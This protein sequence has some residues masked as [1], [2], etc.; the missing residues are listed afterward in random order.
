MR[1]KKSVFRRN[2]HLSHEGSQH[3]SRRKL[4]SY[5]WETRNQW[6]FGKR[7]ACL[8]IKSYNPELFEKRACQQNKWLVNKKRM[9]SNVLRSICQIDLKTY[10]LRHFVRPVKNSVNTHI[11]CN[12]YGSKEFIKYIKPITTTYLLPRCLR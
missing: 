5:L 1:K 7:V 11:F 8:C 4:I 10:D 12:E 3:P 9:I 2:L 6:A